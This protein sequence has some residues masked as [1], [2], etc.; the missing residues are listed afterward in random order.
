MM[1]FAECERHRLLLVLQGK[2]KQMI[3]IY[4][5]KELGIMEYLQVSLLEKG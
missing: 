3:I 2:V 4:Y 5:V 1:I